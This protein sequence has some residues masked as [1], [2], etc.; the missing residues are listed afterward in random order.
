MRTD[1]ADPACPPNVTA[2]AFS[3]TVADVVMLSSEEEGG[4]KPASAPRLVRLEPNPGA[5]AAK[6]EH[7]RVATPGELRTD[8]D[9]IAAEPTSIGSGVKGNVGSTLGIASS[10]S[11]I[12]PHPLLPQGLER[13]HRIGR[14][15]LPLAAERKDFGRL[16]D[17]TCESFRLFSKQLFSMGPGLGFG[18]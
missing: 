13:F 7:W 4:A 17:P 3:S 1:A 15:A 8:W 5:I 10:R 2:S 18:F 11:L 16:L 12:L 6:I 14:Q 9:V